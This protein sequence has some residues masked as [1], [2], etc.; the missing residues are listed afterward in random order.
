[1]TD[2][3]FKQ[4]RHQVG[5]SHVVNNDLIDTNEYKPDI[6]V[7]TRRGKIKFILE[8]EN[9]TDRKA[10][11]GDIIKAEKCAEQFGVRTKLIIVMKEMN[12]TKI[13]QMED[14]L[15]LY[16]DWIKSRFGNP[17]YLSKI[18]LISDIEY[19]NSID[20]E[21]KLGTRRFESYCKKIL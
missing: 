20:N 12:N 1:M 10:F 19:K 18:F 14:H 17:M 4:L 15:K 2:S 7:A 5:R 13:K 16:V 6:V 21:L 11:L 9:K 8:C 3:E